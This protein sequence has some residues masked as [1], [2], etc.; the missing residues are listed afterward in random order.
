MLME[1]EIEMEMELEKCK[2]GERTEK[3]SPSWVW[4][5]DGTWR[6]NVYTETGIFDGFLIGKEEVFRVL[7]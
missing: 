6:V 4:K 3:H 5:D 7:D 1:M 2:P